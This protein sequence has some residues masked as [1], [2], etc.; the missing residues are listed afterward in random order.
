MKILC[1][2]GTTR[3]AGGLF[4][5]V[6]SLCNSLADGE[7][8]VSVLGRCDPFFRDDSEKWGN[9]A[10]SGYRAFGPLGFSFRLRH[11]LS[12]ANADMVHQHGIWLYDQ[13]AASQWQKKTGKPVMVS[14]HGMLDPWALK[15]AAW[16]KKS[17]EKLFAREAL[18][19]ATCI[20]AL[21]RSEVDSIRAYGLRNPV[22]L[23][24]NA[25]VL[26]EI[27]SR[28]AEERGR[29]KQLLFLG[30]IHPKKGLS[31]L[32]HA[33]AG[34]SRDWKL[35]VAGWDDGGHEA[36]LRELVHELGLA[37]SV[38]FIGAQYGGEKEKL[39]RSVD[40]F[41]LPSFSEGLP[42]SVLEAWSYG[43][44]VV[45]TDFCNLPEGFAAEAAIRIEPDP[46]SIFQGL[47]KLAASSDAE[48]K[49]MGSR[50]RELIGGKF[51]WPRVAEEMRQVYE[52]CIAG[53]N[54]PAC[55]EF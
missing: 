49:A 2:S 41:V 6:S 35:L 38:S 23:I 9:V 4:Y 55:M 24:P 17:V 19:R 48:L 29:K 50:G 15:N 3:K 13:W 25:V 39:F 28:R 45:M 21:C 51:T 44:P 53:G 8:S 10:L 33:W 32:L 20:H 31:E 30:R 52:W 18:E 34:F 11:L 27:G 37:D 7:T 5:A 36:G 12:Q 40:A 16:K 14:P 43:V 26:P 54:P 42:M 22:A 46:E 1:L 47:E